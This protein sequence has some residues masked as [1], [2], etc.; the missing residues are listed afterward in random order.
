MKKFGL[1]FG[2]IVLAMLFCNTSFAQGKYGTGQDSVNCVNFLNFYKDYLKQGDYKEAAP[3]WSNAYKYCPHTA[4]QTM[5]LDGQKIMRHKLEATNLTPELRAKYI[6]T[7]L[8]LGDVRAESFPKY[9]TRAKENKMFD[10]ITYL[11][12]QKKIFAALDQVISEEGTNIHCDL[13]VAA[14][15]AVCTLYKEKKVSDDVVLAAY[16]KISPIF[17]AKV[18]EEPDAKEQQLIFDG[19]FVNSGVATCDNLVAVFTPRFNANPKDKDLV[20]MAV[21]LLADNNCVNTDLFLKTVTALNEMEPSAKSSEYLYKLYSSKDDN[22]NAVKYLHQAIESPDVT[23]EHKASMMFE[24]ATF[25]YKKMNNAGKAM[26]LAREAAELDRNLAG[27]AYF[28]IGTVWMN[29]RCGGNE[30]ERRANFWVATDYFIK[31]KNADPE[32]ASEAEKYMATA[33]HYFPKAEDA[34]MYDITDGNSFSV[35]CGGMSATTTVRTVK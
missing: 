14:M 33:R 17:A 30:I 25:Y 24:L 1:V 5:L 26:N 19:T 21:G 3:L 8:M 7:L 27:K 10:M 28:L 29:T 20:K 15:Q 22:A 6:D 18:K 2:C 31:A 35:N 11:S 4:S 16:S 13:L 23:P 34:F 12:D 32:V 9:A